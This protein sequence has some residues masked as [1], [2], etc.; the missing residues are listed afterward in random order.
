MNTVKKMMKAIWLFIIL[1]IPVLYLDTH[2]RPWFEWNTWLVDGD[3]AAKRRYA[4][5]VTLM[6]NIWV[7]IV[8]TTLVAL[9]IHLIC[10]MDA[11]H[12][13]DNTSIKIID[14]AMFALCSIW[15]LLLSPKIMLSYE[16]WNWMKAHKFLI[17]VYKSENR[18]EKKIEGLVKDF[19]TIELKLASEKDE[20]KVFNHLE[21]VMRSLDA[22]KGR[23][24]D[25]VEIE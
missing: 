16:T 23:R 10:I 14:T 8:L 13:I 24:K 17:R 3:T 4:S 20:Y 2:G 18:D 25:L 1:P 19:L 22:W 9:L 15:I 5:S 12:H 21:D 6:F 7:G 11:G